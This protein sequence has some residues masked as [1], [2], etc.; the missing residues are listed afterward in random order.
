M[1]FYDGVTTVDKGRAINVIYLDFCK[2][3]DTVLHNILLSTL[4]RYGFDGW[5]VQ[6]IRNWL[7]GLSQRVV[8]NGSVSRWRQMT[9][10]VPQR[11]ILG[12]VLFNIFTNDRQQDQVHAQQVCR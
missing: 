9:N 10:G 5:T 2:A 8:V 7:E 11:S 1:A 12:L 3:F 4:G 6:W